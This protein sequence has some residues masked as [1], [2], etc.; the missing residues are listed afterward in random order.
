M[1]FLAPLFL[2]ALG[3]LAVPV[4]IHLI[5]RE[6]KRVVAFP[7]LMFLRRI[8]YQSVRRR[9]IRHW[10]LLA[11]RLAALL[12][13]VLAFAR[14]FLRRHEA[15]AAAAAGAR[16]VAILLDRSFSMGYG[17]HWDRARRAATQAVDALGRNDRASLIL[18]ATGAEAIVR[19]AGDRGALHAAIDAA[20]VSSAAT[21]YGPAL[22]L[23]QSI[24]SQSS[25]ARR[26]VVLISDFQAMA[27]KP[28]EGVRL[29]EG[30]TLKP[31][32]VAEASTSNIV[33]STA[34]P[35]RGLFSGQERVAI[36]AALINRST[37]P[38]GN[39]EV[40]LDIDGRAVQTLP[41][42]I[43]AGGSSAVTFAPVTLSA[44]FTRGTVRVG[45]DALS[46]DNTHHFVMSPGRPLGVLIVDRANAARDASLYLTKA[47]AIGRAPS[48]QTGITRIDRFAASDLDASTS[49]SAPSVVILNDVP[50]PGAAARWLQQFVEGGGGLLVALGERSAWPEDGPALL[51]G[52]IGS[53]VDRSTGRGGSLVVDF[54]H[55]VFELFKAPR[56]GD[57]STARFF[58]YRTLT[59][60]PNSPA[61]Q[62][63]P[64]ATTVMA[65][66]DDGAT[67]LVERR[68]GAGRVAVWTTTLDSFW[69]D[70][71][72]KPVFL[73]FVHR[74]VQYLAD[75]VEPAG[76]MTVGQVLDARGML[77]AAG[78]GRTGDLPDDAF[79][80][81]PSGTRLRLAEGDQAGVFELAEQGFYEVHSRAQGSGR[82]VTVA[83]N[84]DRAESDLTS[85]DPHELVVAVSGRGGA[86]RSAQASEELN[87]TVQERRQAV[88]WYLLIVGILMLA[89]ET[90]LSNRLSR[91]GERVG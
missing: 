29:G 21:R 88:W 34:T 47:L 37:A 81:T 48:F 9:R 54:T 49:S 30:V 22:K 59:L 61:G 63:P 74:L 64:A 18:F 39:V 67:A 57:F 36:S 62:S 41:A 85:F 82:A 32:S 13:I 31:V 45:G 76:W 8:P 51:P 73:P 55:P 15:T 16:E 14:P 42:R 2:V 10:L 78:D 3:A 60:T 38:A 27:W 86:E 77:R 52:S 44:P 23:A 79:V 89:A 35:Q 12:L 87:P 56:S 26:E 43:D 11:L 53:P 19:S 17:D 71:A 66:F 5:Q 83:V 28:D 25:L 50:P 91:M 69:N 4:L 58:R 46:A 20:H 24:L 70:L 68:I 7:S 80:L 40:T 1:A 90:V 6:R 65:R 33:V 72:L 75:Y 84:A